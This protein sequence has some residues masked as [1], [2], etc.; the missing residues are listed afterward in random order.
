MSA[1]WMRIGAVLGFL[2]VA[3]GAFG[4]HGLRDLVSTQALGWWETGA[5]YA[6]AHAVALLAVAWLADRA[7]SRAVHVAGAAF[8]LGVV[9]FTGSLW[10][11]TITDIRILGAITPLGGTS[12]ILGWVALVVAAGGLADRP[13]A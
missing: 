10:V 12:I 2:A 5:Q 11:M 8:A 9:V 4:A 3:G 1:I 6:L 7:P 13:S